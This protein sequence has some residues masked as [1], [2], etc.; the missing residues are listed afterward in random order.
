MLRRI[1]DMRKLGCVACVAAVLLHCAGVVDAA[2]QPRVKTTQRG[3]FVAIG[4]TFGQN[5]QSSVPKPV[6]GTVSNCGSNTDD[7]S[8]DVFWFSDDAAGTAVA[9]RLVLPEDTGST[10]VLKLPDGAEVTNAYLYW[11]GEKP[12]GGGTAGDKATIERAGVETLT[13]Q[14]D[15]TFV[16]TYSGQTFFQSVKDVTEFVSNHGSGSYRVSGVRI[17]DF[18]DSNRG[19]TF[20]AWSLIVLYADDSE[21]TRNMVIFDG[22][23]TVS[24]G[25]VT[26]KLEGFQV[27]DAGFQAK[28][29]VIAY[30]G[31][32][33]LTGD[34][35][36]FGRTSP[37]G[38]LDALS[39]ALNPANNFFNSTRSHLGHAVSNI[40]DLPQLT[41]EPNSMSSYDLDVVDVTSRLKAGDTTAHIAATSSGDVFFLGAFV[42]SISTLA[43][44][45]G[46]SMKT[47]KDMNGGTIRPGDLLRYTIVVKNEGNDVASGVNLVDELP[48]GVTYKPGSIAIVDGAH[49][50]PKTD[51]VDEDQGEYDTATRTVT[52]RLGEGADGSV[53]G[54]LAVGES[55]TVQFDVYIDSDFVG[56]IENQAEIWFDGASGGV[57]STPTTGEEDNPGAPTIVVV[58][59][60]DSTAPCADKSKPACDESQHP[61]RCVECLTD[62]QCAGITPVCDSSHECVPCVDDG[63]C[64]D[65]DWG[66][67]MESGACGQCNDSDLSL[68]DGKNPVCG[69]PDGICLDC[70]VDSTGEC[71]S[72]VTDSN[73][74]NQSSGTVCYGNICVY[75]C[76]G[77][78]GNGCPSGQ[79]CS[80]DDGGIGQ[81][82]DVG[83]G[84]GGGGGGSGGD[85]SDWDAGGGSGGSRRG[86]ALE[87]GGYSCALPVSTS[88]PI[89]GVVFVMLGSLLGLRLRDR[90][91][92]RERNRS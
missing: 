40:G 70:L 77:E 60:C 66:I 74:G 31:D 41:G 47:V 5:C 46:G 54:V 85:R 67:C 73:C 24:S 52:V 80:S 7:T 26:A 23:D 38:P 14:P 64:K 19:I 20:G 75:G 37:L 83:I 86:A 78:G 49:A 16:A 30:E 9:N 91:R 45:F 17:R 90:W 36:R 48:V 33:S 56:T 58:D 35:L 44:E 6:V 84:G 4:N 62:G 71:K 92:D 50:G 8:P 10:A 22:L 21:P 18:R 55:A 25:S 76:R 11:A 81:C 53:G 89:G 43:P 79:E 88:A 68:C 69:M 61:H 28:L 57:V 39:D 12:S 32:E 42:T 2:P 15:S 1:R 59:E 34:E 13:V 3:D 82:V 87:G 63:S 51:V 72:C 29:G 27:P 65:P